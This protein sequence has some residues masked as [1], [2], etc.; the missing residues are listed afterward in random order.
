MRPRLVPGPG[1]VPARRRLAGAPVA[2]PSSASSH[3]AV[4]RLSRGFP[5][6][7]VRLASLGARAAGRA[8]AGSRRRPA[9]LRAALHPTP[10]ANTQSP[11]R[12][13]A[14]DG[15][16]ATSAGAATSGRPGSVVTRPALTVGVQK[17]ERCTSAMGQSRH[18]AAV[19]LMRGVATLAARSAPPSSSF[20]SFPASHRPV[21]A[22]ATVG[23]FPPHATL[24]VPPI[25]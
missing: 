14:R 13:R 1:R 22:R 4:M 3:H 21:Q 2:A 19:S 17:G 11:P 7:R 5:R 15:D 10:P 23:V 24:E 8:R 6:D 12:R 20:P 18:P 9:A 25:D 16:R